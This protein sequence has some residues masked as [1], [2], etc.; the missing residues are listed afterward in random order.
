[1]HRK[2]KHRTWEAREKKVDIET[3]KGGRDGTSIPT[4]ERKGNE[5]EQQ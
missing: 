2:R 3:A 4:K 5:M 1:M